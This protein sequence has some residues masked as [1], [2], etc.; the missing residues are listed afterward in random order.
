MGVWSHRHAKNLVLRRNTSVL[1][2]CIVYV[3]SLNT[4]KSPL[5]SSG[6]SLTEISLLRHQLCANLLVLMGSQSPVACF[7]VQA[8]ILLCIKIQ[9]N[10]TVFFPSE[11]FFPLT[12]QH[13]HSRKLEKEKKIEGECC[14]CSSLSTE[15]SL[16]NHLSPT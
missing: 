16:A 2:S 6:G 8:C 10:K 12:K 9:L 14:L 7:L 13:L 5:V 11:S 3:S 15:L 4:G 1:L